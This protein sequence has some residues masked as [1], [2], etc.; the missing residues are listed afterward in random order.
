M[1]SKKILIQVDVTTK[2]AEVQ[3]NKVIESMGKLEGA[4]TKVSTAQKKSTASAGLH[5]AILMEAGRTASDLN[6]GFSAVANNLGQLFSLFQASANSAEGLGA[7]FKKLLSIQALFLIGGQLVIQNLDKITSFFK[8]VVFGIEDFNK[9]FNKASDT[10][11]DVN[12]NFEL[13]IATLE[14][15]T[16]S[17]DEKAIAIEKLNEEY[18]DYIDSLQKADVSLQDVKNKTKAASLQNDLYRDSIMQL[19]IARAAEN[20]LEKISTEILQSE[21][22]LKND[23]LEMGF[24]T[25]DQVKERIKLLDDL[26]ATEKENEKQLKNNQHENDLMTKIY[27]NQT[28]SMTSN[29]SKLE[30]EK[31]ALEGTAKAYGGLGESIRE[32]IDRLKEERERYLEFIDLKRTETKKDID[33]ENEYKETKIGNV[34]KEVASIKALGRIRSKFFKK[35]QDQ[36]V[37]DK[38]TAL[39]KSELQR[40]QAL[41]EVNAIEGNEIAKRQA[42]LEINAFY[43]KKDIQATE[44]TEKAKAKIDK[45][46]KEAKLQQLDDIGEGLMAA[47]EIAGKATGLGKGLAVAATTISTY[48]AAQKAYDSQLIVGDPTSIVRAQIAAASAVLQG[49]AKVKAIMSVKTPAMK[50]GD[51]TSGTSTTPV[52]APDFNVVGQSATS[53][54]VGAVQNQFGTALRAYVVSGDISSAQELDRKIN[55]T[56]VI[57]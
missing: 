25:E 45:L 10:V 9:I 12:G 48:G 3:I 11:K 53:Q 8:D 5:N 36:D 14:D 19:A 33:L 40:I 43:D 35:N 57:G 4:T 6:Y 20:E 7:A 49:L 32:R 21:I 17:E 31:A 23:Q 22:D 30:D 41:A 38:E 55:T 50:G 39:E 28:R 13:Y 15:V 37:K 2:S 52:Q 27:S 46:A 56:S 54:L 16:K 47:S 51:S 18:P 29:L 24:K 44:E 34:D 42:R 26:I 1:A